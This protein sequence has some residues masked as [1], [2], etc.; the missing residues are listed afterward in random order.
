MIIQEE[1]NVRVTAMCPASDRS[2]SK[3]SAEYESHNEV[4]KED[5]IHLIT[6]T[7]TKR[8]LLTCTILGLLATNVLTLTS[9]AF[10][11]AIS[12]EAI[13]ILG[14]GILLAGTAYELYCG[15]QSRHGWQQARQKSS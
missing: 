12:G 14:V 13:P 1:S 8:L 15:W 7:W 5:G 6:I 3:T 4:L 2:S 11:A 10:N 9:T